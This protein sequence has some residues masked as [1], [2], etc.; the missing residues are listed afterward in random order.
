MQARSTSERFPGKCF[1]KIGDELSMIEWVLEAARQS[2]RFI[3]G[4]SYYRTTVTVVALV[5]RGDPLVSFLSEKGYAVVV[6]DEHHVLSRYKELLDTFQADY[7]VRLT[8]DCPLIPPF[9]IT[10]H[11]KVAVQDRLDYCSNVSPDWRTEADGRD[12]EVMSR[13]TLQWLTVNVCD[14]LDAEHV[15][16]LLRREPPDWLKEG[17][18]IG[19]MDHSALK[20]SVDTPEDLA[21]VRDQVDR[22]KKKEAVARQGT[23][24]IYKY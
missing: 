21:R 24:L 5:P 16:T 1:E 23:A 2:A 6:G 3:N 12:C 19:F 15:T 11:V 13:Q 17:R 20:F 22:L 4:T 9:L 14:P 10:K 18:V 8:G 7:I